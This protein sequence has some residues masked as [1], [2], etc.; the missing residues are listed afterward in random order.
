M[1][2][3]AR[4]TARCAR[5]RSGEPCCTCAGPRRRNANGHLTKSDD[6]WVETP[7]SQS[8]RKVP[9]SEAPK[10][11]PEPFLLCAANQW[12]YCRCINACEARGQ[13]GRATMGKGSSSRSTNASLEGL[14]RSQTLTESCTHCTNIALQ[15]FTTGVATM[16]AS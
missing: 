5:R 9:D 3:G 15:V 16:V 13:T 1:Q 2:A 10:K 11:T 6:S 4:R 7:R 14:C 12:E 8:F